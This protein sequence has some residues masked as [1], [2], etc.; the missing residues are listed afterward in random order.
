MQ[1]I[2]SLLWTFFG[3]TLL[4]VEAQLMQLNL[5]LFGCL[6]TQSP[7]LNYSHL[8]QDCLSRLCRLS[9]MSRS[10]STSSIAKR[11]SLASTVS[12]ARRSLHLAQT[13][14]NRCCRRLADSVAQRLLALSLEVAATPSV[15]VVV[16]PE[17]CEVSTSI[18]K[19]LVCM[20]STEHRLHLSAFIR[21][22]GQITT[23]AR[24]VT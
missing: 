9:I 1:S 8:M 6:R 13:H 3:Q 17:T 15:V 22:A 19:L 10:V 5:S 4:L 20:L 2:F 23:H 16:V 7:L 11:A 24:A 18:I 14:A 12:D 21:P